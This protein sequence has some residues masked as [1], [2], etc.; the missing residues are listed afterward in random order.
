VLIVARQQLR[1]EE[2]DRDLPPEGLVGGEEDARETT[3]T[4]LSIEPEPL[5]QD[6]AIAHIAAATIP[7]APFR[8]TIPYGATPPP[9]TDRP[10][11]RFRTAPLCELR[12]PD[13]AARAIVN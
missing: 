12:P 11:V 3:P 9:I 1:V 8:L 6:V 13:S 2:F 4:D 7:F 10:P 5:L